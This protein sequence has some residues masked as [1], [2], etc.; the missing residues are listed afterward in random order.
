MTN[1]DLKT[2]IDTQITNET[3][4][5]G[6]T[7][8]DVGGNLKSVVDYTDQQDALKENISNKSINVVTD[9]ASDL[10]YPSVKAVKDYVDQQLTSYVSYTAMLSQIGTDAPTAI[11]LKNDANLTVTLTRTNVGKYKA[12]LSTAI[13]RT[14]TPVIIASGSLAYINSAAF[15]STTIINIFTYDITGGTVTYYDGRL[16]NTFFE[17]RVYN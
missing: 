8:T 9:G 2:Q 1:T 14:K 17:I 11:I 4:K 15:Q 12:T 6:I 10:K 3:V 7:P 16:D 13:D 5:S